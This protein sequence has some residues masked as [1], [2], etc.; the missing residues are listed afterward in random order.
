MRDNRFAA[1]MGSG[2]VVALVAMLAIAGCSRLS[3]IKPDLGRGSYTQVAPEIRMTPDRYDSKA[4]IARA[5][6]QKGQLALAQ[7]DLAAATEASGQA[8]R[9]APELASSQTLAALVAERHGQQAKAGAHYRR[10]VELAPQQGGMHNNYGTWLCS[11][12][13]ARES[14]EWFD[15]ALADPA[16]PT[17]AVA[18][19]NAGA[20]ANQAGDAA[21]AV[22]YLVRALELDP[23]NPVALGAMAEHE[24][25]TGEAFRARAFSQRRLAAAPADARSLMLASQIEEKLGDRDAAAVYVQRLRAEFPGTPGSG[26]GDNGKR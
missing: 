25:R 20:C 5:A 2:V 26:T 12:G 14:L 3:F 4:A 8:V 17:P 24:F 16:Y 13:R 1:R 9:A 11:N 18:L 7:G 23:V 22:R 10:A 6:V 21:L 19:A 15:H